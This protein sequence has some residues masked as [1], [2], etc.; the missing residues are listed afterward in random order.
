MTRAAWTGKPI[1][2]LLLED[3]PEDAAL[4]QRRLESSSLPFAITNVGSADEFKLEISTK[5]YDV[6]LG[7]YRLPNWTGLDAVRWLRSSGYSVPFILLTGTLGDELA[8]E[9]I[10]EGANDYVLKDKIERL[11]F[12]LMRAVEESRMRKERDQKE[13]E[14]SQSERKLS[15]SEYNLGQSEHNLGQSE[16]NLSQ[17]EIELHKSER[18]FASII[19]GAPYGIFRSDDTGRILMANPALT[20]MLGYGSEAEVLKLNLEKDVYAQASDRRDIL[21]KLDGENKFSCAEVKWRHKNG[22]IIIV[23][24]D[25]WRLETEPGETAVY[26]AFAQDITEQRLLQQQFQQAQKM[27]AIG[28]LA[29][30]VAHDFNNLLMIIRGCAELLDYHKAD[31]QKIGGYIKQ[32]NDATSIA[33][34]VVQQLMA[35]SRKQSPEKSALDFNAVLRDLRKMLPRLLGE[36]IQVVFTLGPTLERV[37]ADRAQFEQIILNLAVNARDAMP[38]GGKLVLATSNV[39]L[40]TPQLESGG[41]ELP[42]GNYVLLSVTD[43]GTGME[44]D[45]QSH[46]FEP[47]FTTKER[48]KGTGLGLATVYGIVKENQGFIAVDSTPGKGTTLKIYFPVNL[49]AR[50]AAAPVQTAHG[51][52]GSETI[53]L[54]EDEAALREI[55][56]EYLQSRGYNV[57]SAS[58]GLQALEFCRTYGSPIDIL[59]TDII[60]PGIQGPE[61]VKLA[62]EMRPQMHVIYVSGYT[63]RGLEIVGADSSAVLLRKPYSLADLGHTIRSTA[64]VASANQ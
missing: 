15:Q 51:P 41:V 47:F 35:F 46:I 36:D 62:L 34:S 14:L 12:A 33:A 56:C 30:G 55:T 44:Q 58:S 2:I 64:S 9:C 61:L 53:L 13:Q 54:V 3:D 28:R 20:K 11:P 45:V 18:Q 52:G 63:D 1:A 42:P 49:E 48:G 8:V 17:S 39:R 16:Y 6:I 32:I 19:R 59:M 7:D 43:N 50:E 37:S 23:Q 5:S 4:C 10:I 24:L 22:K 21:G 57:L 31:P 60:M 25:G 40:K 27:E 29:G 38:A 26:K